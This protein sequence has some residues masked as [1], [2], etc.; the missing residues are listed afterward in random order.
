MI[1]KH[2]CASSSSSSKAAVQRLKRNA[3]LVGS[4]LILLCSLKQGCVLIPPSRQQGHIYYYL[5]KVV[6]YKR[7]YKYMACNA[8]RHRKHINLTVL[9]SAQNKN[10]LFKNG[11]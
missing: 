11:T 8:W 3:Y 9:K 1:K 10:D 6:P 4:S 5:A 2:K 7:Y